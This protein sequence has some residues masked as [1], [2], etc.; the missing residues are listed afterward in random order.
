MWQVIDEDGK[1][2]KPRVEREKRKPG[3]VSLE[4]DLPKT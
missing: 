2:Q 4:A 3:V 1:R